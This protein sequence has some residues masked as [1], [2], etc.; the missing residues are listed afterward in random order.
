MDYPLQLAKLITN[1]AN[2]AWDSG[3]FIQSVTPQTEKLLKFWFSQDYIDSRDKNFHEGQKQSILNT[4][5]VHEVLKA[6]NISEIYE[7]I[8]PTLYI[9]NLTEISKDSSKYP[10]YCIK[11]ATGTGKTWVL[12]ALLIWQYLN[13]KDGYD[14]FSKNFLIIAPGLIVYE[15]LLDA[16][17]GKVDE[18]KKERIFEKS[19]IFN[20]QDLFIP[21][22]DR[23][24]IFGFIQ[25]STVRRDEIGKPTGGG[26]IAITNWN[27]LIDNGE[28]KK[29]SI[30]VIPEASEV[31]KDIFPIRPGKNQGND[32]NIL[33]NSYN[34]GKE[35]EYLKELENLVV[36]NDEAH[37]IHDI[38]KGEDSSEVKWKQSLNI[39]SK[40]KGENFIQ[41]DFSATP[42][43]EINKKKKY[44]SHIVSDFDLKD[45]IKKGLVKTLVL[46]LRKEIAAL[47]LD[48]KALR[49]DSNKIRGLSDGQRIM[50]RAGITKLK[51]LEEE[52]SKV[53]DNKNP[54]ML[55]ICEETEVTKYVREFLIEEN[56][57][58]E[59]IMEIHS[60]R[61]GEVS[62][63]EWND[64]KNR[65]F[66]IDN[67][68]IPKAIISV[69]MLREGFDVNNICV[70]VPLRATQ[71]GI[72]LEQ[73]IG[74]GLRLMWRETEFQDIKLEDRKR[75]LQKHIDPESQYDILSIIEHPS[76]REFY[77]ELIEEGLVGV[78]E[79]E[80]DE[81]K[82]H[83]LGDIIWSQL[84]DNY[85]EYDFSIPFIKRDVEEQIK[86]NI[87]SVNNLKPFDLMTFE[88]LK[89]L[90]PKSEV[91]QSNE[92]TS[93]TKFGDYAVNG[94]MMT[95]NSYN[96]YISRLVNRVSDL[97]NTHISGK[98]LNEDKKY[99]SLQINLSK[100]ASLTD[101]YIKKRLFN[102]NINPLEDNNWRVLL[103]D[104]VANHIISQVSN[105]IIEAQATEVINDP[106]VIYK[107]ISDIKQIRIREEYSIET[108][109]TIY[110]RTPFPSNKGGFEKSFIEFADISADVLAFVKII[111]NFHDFIK[112]RYIKDDGLSSYYYPDFLVRCKNNITYLVETKSHKDMA[113]INVRRKKI[114]AENFISQINKLSE[115][116]RFNNQWEYVLL[117][118][119][120]FYS[121]KNRM[122]NMI[123]ILEYTKLQKKVNNFLDM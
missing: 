104:I 29:E 105:A 112:I 49:D 17:L 75:L 80:V 46:D 25:N 36:F 106:E 83:S 14:F 44:F 26:V 66:N 92:V 109:K 103:L 18:V 95:A 62:E 69:L 47:P 8:N 85:E 96:E 45:A 6:K 71:S 91:F 58:D 121:L 48:F 86:D 90:A 40:N 1:K 73:T 65:L 27:V 2:N 13:A 67:H 31:I 89:K 23:D 15:R 94:G 19:D 42:Y 32:L 74:R 12:I 38:K 41:I 82:E 100:I 30:S 37:H 34:R 108:G 59:D 21:N 97:G 22:I 5:Y 61:K 55:V 3:E 115:E 11:M 123:D 28:D 9:D 20:M 101:E 53:S 52:F 84:K 51:T 117:D 70:I 77:N 56:L 110:T 72:L 87:I 60:S 76:F 99:P 39:I 7:K 4:I 10:K 54:K 57:K 79:E 122:A 118:E 93:K 16:F 33:D 107:K 68:K 24:E 78:S 102:I 43:T 111:E 113:D 116:K 114:S 81:L 88:N 98:H 119:N 63:D 120:D 64:I 50:L 35:L